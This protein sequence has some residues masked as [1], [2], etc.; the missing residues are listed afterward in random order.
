MAGPI[1]LA[2]ILLYFKLRHWKFAADATIF[3]IIFYLLRSWYRYPL[4][5]RLHRENSG[6]RNFASNVCKTNRANDYL[7]SLPF[8]S[9]RCCFIFMGHSQPADS[10]LVATD[11][12]ICS[13]RE[14]AQCPVGYLYLSPSWTHKGPRVCPPIKFQAGCSLNGNNKTGSSYSKVTHFC[15]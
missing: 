14:T 13:L 3:Q 10:D 15:L 4:F 8:E 7:W 11:E 12:S 5:H 1:E 9:R 6:C 2:S